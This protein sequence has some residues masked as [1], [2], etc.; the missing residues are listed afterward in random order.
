[1]DSSCARWAT[2]WASLLI[3]VLHFCVERQDHILRHNWNENKQRETN[4]INCQWHKFF[5][6]RSE[7][8]RCGFMDGVVTKTPQRTKH[9]KKIFIYCEE[10]GAATRTM[11]MNLLVTIWPEKKRAAYTQLDAVDV[12]A[13]ACSAS[14]YIH[15]RECRLFSELSVFCVWTCEALPYRGGKKKFFWVCFMLVGFVQKSWDA[16]KMIEFLKEFLIF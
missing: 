16:K 11:M 2:L 7:R 4:L 15:S 5:S 14:S 9:N 8:V 13:A 10:A 1:M 3:H 6:F 12:V